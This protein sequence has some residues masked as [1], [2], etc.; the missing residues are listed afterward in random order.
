MGCQTCLASEMMGKGRSSTIGQ[1]ASGGSD[2][3]PGSLWTP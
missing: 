3:T 1:G 2:A